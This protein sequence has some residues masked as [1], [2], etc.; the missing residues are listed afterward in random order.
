VLVERHFGTRLVFIRHRLIQD[1]SIP[2]FLHVRGNTQ[3][4]PKRVV[5][6]AGSDI[7]VPAFGQRLILVES[8][9]VLQLGGRQFQDALARTF[10]DQMDKAKQ[11]LIGIPESHSASNPGLKI[12]G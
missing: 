7:V 11:V 1:G 2:G 9:A 4:Q 12:A 6:E 3:D 10:R 8:S 5:I